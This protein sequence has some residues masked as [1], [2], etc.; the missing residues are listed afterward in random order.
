MCCGEA[1]FAGLVFVGFGEL[2]DAVGLRERKRAEQDAVDDREDSGV[3]SDAESEGEDGGGGEAGRFCQDAK[4][5]AD[6][7]PEG[8]HQRL[9]RKVRKSAEDSFICNF[10]RFP[11]AMSVAL[12]I[13]MGAGGL[14][15]F[16]FLRV[17]GA[18]IPI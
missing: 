11:L 1:H 10:H 3:G 16:R 13:A 8:F 9:R 12:L 5:E 6:V 15:R 17:I 7:L 2:D 14:P 4:A 18:L